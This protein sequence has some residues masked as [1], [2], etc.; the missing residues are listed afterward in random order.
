[1]TKKPLYNPVRILEKKRKLLQRARAFTFEWKIGLE[2]NARNGSVFFLVIV[3]CHRS[4]KNKLLIEKA[5]SVNK[6]APNDLALIQ[7][8]ESDKVSRLFFAGMVFVFARYQ[9]KFGN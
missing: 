5:R 7:S 6:N 4:L 1:M 2:W 3:C 9:T 8:R